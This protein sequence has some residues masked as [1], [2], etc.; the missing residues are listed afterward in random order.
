MKHIIITI[1]F[2]NIK[3]ILPEEIIKLRPKNSFAYIYDEP[4]LKAKKI[5]KIKENLAFSKEQ[6]KIKIETPPID[7]GFWIQLKKP[8]GWIFTKDIVIDIE[9]DDNCNDSLEIPSKL[10]LGGIE[11][12]ILPDNLFLISSNE[13]GSS[14]NQQVGVWKSDKGNF[15]GI[16]YF[17]D[18]TMTDCLNICYED[19]FTSNCKKSCEKEAKEEFGTSVITAKLNFLLRIKGNKKMLVLK[20]IKGLPKNVKTFFQSIN[21]EENK[22]YKTECITH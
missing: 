20:S 5:F 15:E 10:F 11:V 7:F 4:N 18:S 3:P 21:I 2:L 12:I 17:E 6:L 9:N 8:N 22:L 13:L 14:F 16:I 19:E 1:L